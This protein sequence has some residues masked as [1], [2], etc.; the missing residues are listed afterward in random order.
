[1]EL[2]SRISR[3]LYEIKIEL[4]TSVLLQCRLPA[5]ASFPYVHAMVSKRSINSNRCHPFRRGSVYSAELSVRVVTMYIRRFQDKFSRKN[6][7]D[8]MRHCSTI[9]RK[10]SVCG[11]IYHEVEA[12]GL[13]STSEWI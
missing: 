9:K 2:K 6:S 7:I 1:M 8:S 5:C 3:L 10:T 4:Y 11:K 12:R 13:C